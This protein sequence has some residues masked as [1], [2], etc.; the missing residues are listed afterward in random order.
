MALQQMRFS[1]TGISVNKQGV[2][3]FNLTF[4][5]GLRRRVS[6]F[7]GIPNDEPLEGIFLLGGVPGLVGVIFLL[8]E[9]QNVKLAG[10]KL[11]E[12]AFSKNRGT[13]PQ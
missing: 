12:C 1:E 11:S 13:G 6:K 8:T 9:H 4:R 2:K 10:K 5:D 3:I 7:I